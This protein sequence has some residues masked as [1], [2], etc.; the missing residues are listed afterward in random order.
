MGLSESLEF[1]LLSVPFRDLHLLDSGNGQEGLCQNRLRSRNRKSKAV[2]PNKKGT[3]Q[4]HFFLLNIALI[5]FLPV[6][7]FYFE[8]VVMY[9]KATYFQSIRFLY[10]C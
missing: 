9:F 2:F 3:K 5:Q 10:A 6:F 8:F 7:F 1:G 4:T